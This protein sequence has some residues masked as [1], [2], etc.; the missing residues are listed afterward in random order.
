[1]VQKYVTAW[2]IHTYFFAHGLRNHMLY[3][4]GA[5]KQIIFCKSGLLIIPSS[6][7]INFVRVFFLHLDAKKNQSR[8]DDCQIV[9]YLIWWFFKEEC[10]EVKEKKKGLKNF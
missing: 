4:E 8:Q 1:M 5:P 9:F 3:R 7:K 10:T 2:K 6:A